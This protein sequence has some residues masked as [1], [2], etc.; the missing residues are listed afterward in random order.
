MTHNSRR[1]IGLGVATIVVAGF[2]WGTRGAAEGPRKSDADPAVERA[3]QQVRMLDDIYKTSVVAITDKY[4]HK[5]T[6]LPAATVAMSLFEA[7]KK[8]GWHESRLID[9]T[10]QPYDDK[11]VAKDD[12]EKAAIKAL[13]G[14]KDYYEELV[15]VDGKPRLRAA[16]P[17]PVVMKKCT[18]CHENFATVKPGVPIGVLTYDVP[19]K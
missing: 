13:L 15:T 9:A 1:W 7:M 6:D 10:G 18:M 5:E 19:I 11:N 14:G 4:V 16:T 2:A 12:F 8:K 17:V 3:R